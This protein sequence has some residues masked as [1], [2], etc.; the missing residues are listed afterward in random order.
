MQAW[1][2]ASPPVP[3]GSRSPPAPWR[4]RWQGLSPLARDIIL[5]LLVKAVVLGGLWYAFFRAPAAR[6]MAMDP[7]RVERQF[8][9]PRPDPEPPHAVR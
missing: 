3:A 7:A 2:Q 4:G 6:Q 9:A 5:V 1:R 8:V